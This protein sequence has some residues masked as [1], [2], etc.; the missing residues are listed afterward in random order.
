VIDDVTRAALQI[1][2]IRRGMSPSPIEGAEG[3]RE[4]F[5]LLTK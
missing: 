1:G 2:L 4:F 3:N 5:L